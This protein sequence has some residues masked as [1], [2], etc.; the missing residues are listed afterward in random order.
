MQ[1]TSAILDQNHLIRKRNI[2]ISTTESPYES[3]KGIQTSMSFRSRLKENDYLILLIAYNYTTFH[4][5]DIFSL[6]NLNYLLFYLIHR[7]YSGTS[8][9]NHRSI[10]I[11]MLI[12]FSISCISISI[13]R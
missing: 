3:M 7:V 5:A 9:F 11:Y 10:C 2:D 8:V 12:F 6:K 1:N 13:L 4:S